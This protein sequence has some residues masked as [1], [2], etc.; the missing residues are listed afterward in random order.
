M[1]QFDAAFGKPRAIITEETLTDRIAKE[2]GELVELS[3]RGNNPTG[4]K[5]ALLLEFLFCITC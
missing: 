2:T 3:S 5:V 1:G 4:G